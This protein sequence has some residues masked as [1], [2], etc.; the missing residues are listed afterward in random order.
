LHLGFWNDS[1]ISPTIK[2]VS[3]TETVKDALWDNERFIIDYDSGLA[4]NALKPILRRKS[5]EV[6]KLKIATG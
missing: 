3:W 6:F 5:W 1:N 2:N 4:N